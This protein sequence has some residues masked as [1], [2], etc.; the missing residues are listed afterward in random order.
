MTFKRI[1]IEF[2][3]LFL[4]VAAAFSE[5]KAQT[6]LCGLSLRIFNIEKGETGSWQSI[7]EAKANIVNLTTR[8]RQSFSLQASPPFL[9][10]LTEGNYKITVAKNGYKITH[11]QISLNCDYANSENIVSEVV[12]LWKGKATKVVEMNPSVSVAVGHDSSFK[13]RQQ[14]VPK[15][16]QEINGKA[17]ALKQPSYPSAAKAARASGAVNVRVVI[18][19]LG[20]VVFAKAESGHPLLR[21]AAIT[22]AK[23][24]QFSPT[25][26]SGKPVKVSGII[27]YNFVAQ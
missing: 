17:N 8:K 2:V 16:N 14:K 18:N 9:A 26:L 10:D 12:F 24:S 5:I 19:E 22:A 27:V 1:F 15:Q 3:F 21:A 4:I 23:G 11:K 25:L 7:S 6:N 13:V 20:E